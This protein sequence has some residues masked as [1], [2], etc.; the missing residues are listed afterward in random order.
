M[1]VYY[2]PTRAD[3]LGK[4]TS[5]KL[6]MPHLAAGAPS[7]PPGAGPAMIAIEPSWIV[8]PFHPVNEVSGSHVF[9][10]IHVNATVMASLMKADDLNFRFY[11]VDGQY[12]GF[13]VDFGSVRDLFTKFVDACQ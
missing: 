3:L 9:G 12:Q 4:V 10:A 5:Y 8:E 11:T 2:A 6:V 13:D 7:P 1:N